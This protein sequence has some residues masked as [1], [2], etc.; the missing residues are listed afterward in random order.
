MKLRFFVLE[1]DGAP[2]AGC[3]VDAVVR[4]RIAAPTT[5]TSDQGPAKP[6]V[7]DRSP[8]PESDA[9]PMLAALLG[10]PDDEAGKDVAVTIAT[11]RTDRVG[12]GVIDLDRLDGIPQNLRDAVLLA[13]FLAPGGD[14]RLDIRGGSGGISLLDGT[15][16]EMARLAGGAAAAKKPSS[17][18]VT[19]LGVLGRTITGRGD[20]FIV[21]AGPGT[22]RGPVGHVVD[23][24][25]IDYE[26]SPGSFVVRDPVVTGDDGCCEHLTPATLPERHFPV[27]HVVVHDPEPAGVKDHAPV[28]LASV[29]SPPP[30]DDRIRW[31]R[32]LE[33][34]QTWTSLG[35]SLG[36]IVH[37]LALAPGE[38]TK[39][40]M[41]D[42][43][44][45]ESGSRQGSVAAGDRLTHEQTT[46]RTIDDIVAGQVNEEQSGLTFMAGLAGAA[47]FAYPAYGISAAG[48][49]SIGFGAS[50]VSGNRDMSAQALQDIHHG[51]MQRSNRARHQHSTV[52]VEATAAEG[53]HI[54]TRIVANMNRGHALTVLYYEILRHLA[55][56][57]EFV[58]ADLAVLIPVDLF[59]FDE[60]LARRYRVQLEAALLDPDLAAGFDALE[61][62]AAG[63]AVSQAGEPEQE[64]PPAP[65]PAVSSIA[66][67][68]TTEF[69]TAPR[70]VGIDP[71]PDTGGGMRLTLQVDGRNV[72]VVNQPHLP[73]NPAHET[74]TNITKLPANL[75]QNWNIRT[76]I[77]GTTKTRIATYT[78]T[79][80]VHGMAILG[81]PLAV[82]LMDVSGV[83]VSWTPYPAPFADLADGWNLRKLVV[84][85]TCEDGRTYKVVEHNYTQ[86]G[87]LFPQ[88]SFANVYLDNR[89]ATY[90]KPDLTP[91]GGPVAVPAAPS[92]MIDD[93]LGQRLLNHLNANSYY[94][95]ATVWLAM[96]PRERRLRL[97]GAGIDLSGVA[98]APIAMSGNHLVFRYTG[99]L[100]SHVGVIPATADAGEPVETIV[101]LPTR[102]VFAEAQLGRC[103]AAEER[104]I[105][106][107]WSF[108]ELPV[109]LLPNIDSL[110]AATPQA[111][112][113]LTADQ[114]TG[115]P[116]QIL[117]AAELP[118][119]AGAIAEAL[120]LLGT[121]DIFRDQS[122][123]A[124]VAEVMGKL[125][126]SAKP[127]TL[128]MAGVAAPKESTSSGSKP[129]DSKATE[130]KPEAKSDS[131]SEGTKIPEGSTYSSEK[132]AGFTPTDLADL[133]KA[134]PGL[135]AAIN[136]STADQTSKDDILA[137]LTKGTTETTTSTPTETTTSTAAE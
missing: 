36:E 2:V 49:H 79:N 58:R 33:F 115:E 8:S 4:L 90:T 34:N 48:R 57:T 32:I 73:P 64:D 30:L 65:P 70:A 16:L 108:D 82:D 80:E 9:G 15:L 39:V 114:L 10:D 29:T 88:G 21:V 45:K 124:Q 127:P 26:W 86:S 104:D 60:E 134:L 113:A 93:A 91:A 38:A 117:P 46:D 135:I 110:K 50:T 98:E 42:W 28:N 51:T 11:T 5:A 85:A 99:T 76:E 13:A 78:T 103:S 133:A 111:A 125:I 123:A 121:P 92:A 19:A 14:L 41:I 81:S 68:F 47:D 35:H 96:D 87:E 116:L 136:S 56:R 122:T 95:A 105:T 24:D 106:R 137:R 71:Q 97:V 84:T 120:K 126:A 6:S 72:A 7:D 67:K 55:V 74:F 54:A 31:A 118:D 62:R 44:R 119:H 37:S 109:S 23:P 3:Q 112:F 129:A 25:R 77:S 130:T 132:S 61:R 12:Y 89:D 1:D 94:Y 27:Y 20:A 101:T 66:T 22:R 75:R 83:T 100:P 43:S 52:V 63:A 40:A 128:S 107:Y 18:L 53:N 17:S 59:T 131:K 102:G 69:W